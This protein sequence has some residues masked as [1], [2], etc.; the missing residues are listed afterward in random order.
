VVRAIS[1]WFVSGAVSMVI[2][3]LCFELPGFAWVLGLRVTSH[4]KGW[5]VSDINLEESII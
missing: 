4:E 2:P 1:F 5:F 3:A